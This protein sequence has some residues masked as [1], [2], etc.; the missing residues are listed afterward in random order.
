MN[1]CFTST[2]TEQ[3]MVRVKSFLWLQP[4]TVALDWLGYWAVDSNYETA[5]TA[6]K[7]MADYD[8]EEIW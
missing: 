1:V 3:H 2:M 5:T 8:S 4:D 7:Y 6:W